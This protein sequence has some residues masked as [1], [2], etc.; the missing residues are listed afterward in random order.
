MTKKLTAK[1]LKA[2]TEGTQTRD[3]PKLDTPKLL[4]LSPEECKVMCKDAG[5]EYKDGHEKRVIKYVCSD[6]SKDRAGDIIKQ[7]GWTIDNFRKNP[8]IMGFHNYGD[9]PVGSSIKTEVVEDK[10]KMNVMFATKDMNPKAD[11]AFKMSKAGI[12]KA[13]S[14]GFAPIKFHIPDDDERKELGMNEQGGIIFD[15]QELLEFS[16]CGVPANANALTESISKGIFSKQDFELVYGEEVLEGL[17]AEEKITGKTGT[18]QGHDHSFRVDED[19]KDG[20]ARGNNTNDASAASHTITNGVVQSAGDPSH[21]HSLPSE[22]R[23]EAGIL[24]TKINGKPIKDILLGEDSINKLVREAIEKTLELVP[25]AGAVLSTKNKSLI[26]TAIE[27]MDN[28]VEALKTL[29]E[30]IEP[31]K[32]HDKNKNID[33][34]N[35][36]NST[37]DIDLNDVPASSEEGGLYDEQTIDLELN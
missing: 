19:S 15:K 6:A 23:K 25:K 37:I 36:E 11:M 9:F 4:D 5:V 29:M 12:M 33:T 21:T 10:L 1:E 16:V 28:A 32:D 18:N 14:V 13:G 8:V 30:S 20:T 31:E 3:Y 17:E 7:D 2:R 26:K 35:N 24:E 34:P 22:A 27:G